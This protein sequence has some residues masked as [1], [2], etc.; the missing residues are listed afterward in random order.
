MAQAQG[1]ALASKLIFSFGGL[2][3]PETLKQYTSWHGSPRP[4]LSGLSFA[5]MNQKWAKS[6]RTLVLMCNARGL[7]FKFG[8]TK[9]NKSHQWFDPRFL[10]MQFWKELEI[11]LRLVVPRQSEVLEEPSETSTRSMATTRS[12]PRSSTLASARSR[13]KYLAPKLT[14][15]WPFS[16]QMVMVMSTSM[17]SSLESA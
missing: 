2:S 9:T 13:S 3:L 14:L 12:T 5:L 11:R 6:C 7:K 10:F 17:S 1:G 8:V 4:S 16:T 15:L